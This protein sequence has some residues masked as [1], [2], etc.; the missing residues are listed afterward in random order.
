MSKRLLLAPTRLLLETSHPAR[1]QNLDWDKIEIFTQKVGPNFYSLTAT[2]N[3]D[4][5]HPDGAV[6]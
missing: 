4:P 1:A 5:L 6:H 2:K 3:V